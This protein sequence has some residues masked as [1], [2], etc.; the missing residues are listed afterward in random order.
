MKPA[1]ELPERPTN[2]VGGGEIDV[3]THIGADPNRQT[4]VGVA[5]PDTHAS[6]KKS[7]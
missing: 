4:Y 1:I 5:V 3:S 2:H 7:M 6:E